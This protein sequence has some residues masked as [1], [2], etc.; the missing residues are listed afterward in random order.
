M[1][2]CIIVDIDGTLANNKRRSPYDMSKIK[3][4]PI[5]PAI[6]AIVNRAYENVIV[7]LMSGRPETAMVDTVEWLHKH[8][9]PYHFFYMR[10][11]DDD[12]PDTKVKLALYKEHIQW[13]Y[14][15]LF[16]LDD[17]TRIVDQRRE[18][19]IYTL[20]VNQTREVF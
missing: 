13:K 7:I 20:D 19:G 1:K 2:P 18:M 9:I 10:G 11:E 17:R 8:S 15:V 3:D 12:R 16:A 6:Q 14:N 4:D 5:I